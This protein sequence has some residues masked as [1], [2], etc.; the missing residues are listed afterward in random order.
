MSKGGPEPPCLPR[1]DRGVFWRPRG[2]LFGERQGPCQDDS[3]F[4]TDRRDHRGMTG[5]TDKMA[6]T[7]QKWRTGG[8]DILG[9]K[10]EGASVGL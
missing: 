8:P 10:L 6:K 5:G 1:R 2:K 4:D 7:G 3:S 9:S